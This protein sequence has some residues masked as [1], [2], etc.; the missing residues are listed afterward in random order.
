[1]WSLKA[2]LAMCYLSAC[3]LA[4]AQNPYGY[5]E[6]VD[7]NATVTV[8][9]SIANVDSAGDAIS[10]TNVILT[11]GASAFDNLANTVY[12]DAQ[13]YR[14][15]IR[16]NN[17]LEYEKEYEIGGGG[18]SFGCPVGQT[19]AQT[20]QPADVRFAS[21]HFDHNSDVTIAV[22]CY[23]ALFTYGE[24]VKTI[25]VTATIAPKAYNRVALWKASYKSDGSNW[26][27]PMGSYINEVMIDGNDAF[28]TAAKYGRENGYD[29][30]RSVASAE[31]DASTAL[32]GLTHGHIPGQNEYGYLAHA[33]GH[34]ITTE[35]H[36][37]TWSQISALVADADPVPHYAWVMLYACELGLVESSL[38]GAFAVRNVD[39]VYLGFT[40]EVW[41]YARRKSDGAIL[42]LNN[43]SGLFFDNMA[44][45]Y[46]AAQA[47]TETQIIYV[48]RDGPNSG[49]GSNDVPMN[50][51]GD[52]LTTLKW[53]YLPSAERDAA[54]DNKFANWIKIYEKE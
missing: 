50:L 3:S 39:G 15:E 34:S 48:P 45:G 18:G 33:L 8:Q 49:S 36:W 44:E 11:N 25:T 22:K 12:T 47:L 2:F 29:D 19:Y 28:V 21:T 46:S 40:A 1:M 35:D 16:F 20:H 9:A 17:V 4:M 38:R 37:F 54:P 27:S 31:M 13:F 14:V 43:H 23:F 52:G 5:A 32:F 51:Y 42:G 41:P 10:G 7:E 26:G 53:L 6:T 30:N 24:Y